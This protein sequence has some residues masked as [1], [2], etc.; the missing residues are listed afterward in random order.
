MG[1]LVLDHSNNCAE[2]TGTFIAEE[3]FHHIE[4]KIQKS[5]FLEDRGPQAAYMVSDVP[6]ELW[7][8]RKSDIN[9]M[10]IPFPLGIAS[11][12]IMFISPSLF[13]ILTCI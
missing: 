6:M 3:E 9:I 13:C 4:K 11:F 10:L 8:G 1:W 2:Q 7:G 5:K 12:L